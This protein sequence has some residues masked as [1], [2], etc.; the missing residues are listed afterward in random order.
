MLQS[1]KGMAD[2]GVSPLFLWVV[3]PT[4]TR[5]EPKGMKICRQFY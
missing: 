4:Q 2:G 1:I 5:A 3:E